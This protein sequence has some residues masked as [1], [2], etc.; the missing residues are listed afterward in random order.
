M[1]ALGAAMDKEG[2]VAESG[3]GA[4]K[5]GGALDKFRKKK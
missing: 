4:K 3:G 1:A 5:K 2:N